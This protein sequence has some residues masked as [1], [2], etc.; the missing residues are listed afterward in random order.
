MVNI[1]SVNQDDPKP[2]DY[3]PPEYEGDVI[4]A[5]RFAGW[6][7]FSVF[8]NGC[9]PIPIN[10]DDPY[11]GDVP[12]LNVGSSTIND[13]INHFGE[14]AATYSHG[15]IYVY[16]AFE[17]TWEITYLLPP[18]I[19]VANFGNEHYLILNF[20]ERGILVDQKIENGD[21]RGLC[22]DTGLCQTQAGQIVWFAGDEEETQVKEFP[23][24]S[25]GCGIYLYVD[26]IVSPR[27]TSVA[28]DGENLG[29]IAVVHV[30][31]GF[32]YIEVKRGDHVI[33]AKK[34]TAKPD[35]VKLPVACNENE[36]LFVRLKDRHFDTSTPLLELVDPSTGRKKI[37]RRHLIIP[38]S[39]R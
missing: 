33:I 24:S 17:K 9:I 3:E 36:N 39:S 22:T 10:E 11:A 23:T 34:V 1:E 28:L 16:S 14:P 32:F 27:K 18:A 30:G 15:S 6:L 25:N 8:L 38:Q 19:G 5:L 31:T 35:S 26:G 21:G 4:P 12:D 29:Q 2:T 13:V 7:L 37:K 20:N